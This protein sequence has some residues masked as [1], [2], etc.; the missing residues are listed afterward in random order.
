MSG[1]LSFSVSLFRKRPSN[2]KSQSR[3]DH[4]VYFDPVRIHHHGDI[5]ANDCNARRTTHGY[6]ETSGY[7]MSV[8]RIS[9]IN[10]LYGFVFVHLLAR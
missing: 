6:I 10:G 9:L 2:Q 5:T 3:D 1:S 8:R 7:F 4:G